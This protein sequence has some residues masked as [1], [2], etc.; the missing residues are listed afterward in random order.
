MFVGE[1]RNILKITEPGQYSR[2]FANQ[3][4]KI[5][6]NKITNHKTFLPV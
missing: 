3:K 2:K 4:S 1:W 5:K 6:I